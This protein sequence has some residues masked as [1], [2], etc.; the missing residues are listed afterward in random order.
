MT[1]RGPNGTVDT[2]RGLMRITEHLHVSDAEASS[3]GLREGR[4]VRVRV[5]GERPRILEA[6]PVHIAGGNAL[7]LHLPA[8]EAA[9][10]GP[11]DVVPAEL[12]LDVPEA[13]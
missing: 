7:E 13:P 10:E 4:A 12:L 5:R 8:D 2:D 11:S 6:V 1:L 3:L 9:I